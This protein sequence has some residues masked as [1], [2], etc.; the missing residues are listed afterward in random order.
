LKLLNFIYF[1]T[2]ESAE[3]SCCICFELCYVYWR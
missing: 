1:T 3:N 2:K